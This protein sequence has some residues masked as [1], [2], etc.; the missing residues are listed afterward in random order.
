MAKEFVHLIF[1]QELIKE[2]IIYTAARKFNITPNI[3]RANVTATIGEVTLELSGE[4]E[5]LKKAKEYLVEAGVK[6]EPLLG[7]IIDG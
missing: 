3:R 6:I 7:D 5:N 1:P 4:E 2:P